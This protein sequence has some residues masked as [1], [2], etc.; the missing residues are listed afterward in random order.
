MITIREV[1]ESDYDTIH[2]ALKKAFKVA[3][4]KKELFK[5]YDYCDGPRL[6]DAIVIDKF[7]D[8]VIVNETYLIC[9]TVNEVWYSDHKILAE[10]LVLRINKTEH[11]F[12]CVI[13]ALEQIAKDNGCV[14]ICCGTAFSSND[15]ALANKYREH[16]FSTSGYELYKGV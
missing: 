2:N 3:K 4:R 12:D 11:N 16:G 14:G 7:V 10:S 15:V 9:Y 6:V 5:K 13:N 8:S 1:N